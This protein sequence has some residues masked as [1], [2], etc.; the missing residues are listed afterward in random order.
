M[1]SKEPKEN[2]QSVPAVYPLAGTDT[3]VAGNKRGNV[4]GIAHH[5]GW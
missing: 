3:G 5:I 2:V 1:M 4:D